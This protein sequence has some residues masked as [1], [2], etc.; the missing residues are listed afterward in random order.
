M[1]IALKI[2]YEDN[3]LLV[4]EKPANV[5]IQGDITG[6]VSLLDMGREYIKDK[7]NKPGNVFLGLVHRLDRPVSGVVVFARTSKAAARLSEQFA[8]HTTRKIYWALVQGEIAPEGQFTDRIVRLENGSSAI[9]KSDNGQHA[10]LSYVRKAY[11]DGVSLVEIDLKTGRH[12]QI[13]VQFAS[14]GH[15][16]LGDLRYGS[17][18]RRRIS[19]GQLAL[20]AYSLTLQHP[21]QPTEMTFISTPGGFW[22]KWAEQ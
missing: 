20:H 17:A 5:L 6:D 12:H 3:H 8:N 11:H 19:D 21:T 13:R 4:V 18:E 1:T 10:E 7:Y 14:R 22:K 16:L 15:A 2:L 9:T